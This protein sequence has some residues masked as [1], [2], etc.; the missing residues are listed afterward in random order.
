M[1]ICSSFFFLLHTLSNVNPNALTMCNCLQIFS[2]LGIWT[3][4]NISLLFCPYHILI[5][6]V[7]IITPCIYNPHHIF[8]I[9]LFFS[10]KRAQF[11]HPFT[12]LLFFF[13]VYVISVWFQYQGNA[14]LVNWVKKVLPPLLCLEE[15]EKDSC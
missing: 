5:I 8:H 15:F 6:F 10:F 1:H 11:F 4:F 2:L 13:N 9:Q 14:G 7:D 3:R 12:F